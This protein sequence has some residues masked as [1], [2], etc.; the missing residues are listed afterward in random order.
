LNFGLDG[1]QAD[2]VHVVPYEIGSDLHGGQDGTDGPAGNHHSG[3]LE[4]NGE[5]L[6]RPILVTRR[7]FTCNK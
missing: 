5:F 7:P 1:A 6:P 4:V 3:P 2:Q